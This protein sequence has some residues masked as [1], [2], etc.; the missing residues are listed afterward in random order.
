MKHRLISILLL[1]SML[2]SL[3]PATAVAA[4]EAPVESGA[5]DSAQM[6]TGSDA[7][8]ADGDTASQERDAEVQ[9]VTLEGKGTAA[10]PYRIATAETLVYAAEQMNADTDQTAY[11]AAH[12]VLTDNIDM[13][14]VTYTPIDKFT[15]SFDGQDHTIRNLKIEDEKTG[16]IG[17]YQIAFIRKNGGTI[18][19]LHFEKAFISSAASDQTPY[20]AVAV[21][22]GENLKGAVISR[23]CVMDSEVNAPG[24]PKVAGIVGMSGRDGNNPATVTGC[25]FQGKLTCGPRTGTWGRWPAALQHRTT[26]ARWNTVRQT[27]KSS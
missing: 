7:T 20:A 10:D 26:P 23:C 22:A 11:A 25:R 3:L 2:L 17:D 5:A 21:V 4:E 19:N 18:S 27:R 12:Y 9:T 15:G 6:E 16:S 24:V 8:P 13:Q 14:G 1:L